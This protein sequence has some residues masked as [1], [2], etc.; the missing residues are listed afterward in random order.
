MVDFNTKDDGPHSTVPTSRHPPR[1]RASS[2][3]V[4]TPPPFPTPT[5]GTVLFVDSNASSTHGDGSKARLFTGAKMKNFVLK[6]R[7]LYLKR[8]ILY[9]I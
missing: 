1:S 5:V 7:N 2:R 9:L 4:F 8:D 3:E 6:T